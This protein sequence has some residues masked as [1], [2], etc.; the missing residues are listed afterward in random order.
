VDHV[1]PGGC[2]A[3]YLTTADRS[4]SVGFIAPVSQH[5]CTTDADIEAT[6]RA[7]VGRQPERRS[8]H[9]HQSSDPIHRCRWAEVV[10]GVEAM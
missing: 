6:V 7:A 4:F 10:L 2:P 3:R 9:G 1:L 8:A 5:F